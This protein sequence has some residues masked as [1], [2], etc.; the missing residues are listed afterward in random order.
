MAKPWVTGDETA[1]V[2][3]AD[4]TGGKVDAFEIVKALAIIVRSHE[5]L[6][7]GPDV[8]VPIDLLYAI[9]RKLVGNRRWS[10]QQRAAR[11]AAAAVEHARIR[12]EA[13]K[14]RRRRP[15]LKDTDIAR[16]LCGG[17]NPPVKQ[18]RKHTKLSERAVRT[19]ISSASR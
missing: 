9:A 15:R 14:V 2:I 8:L 1:Q 19:I 5:A 18:D 11:S 6:G 16:V 17:E 3:R 4:K 10:E 13:D 7:E 12:A